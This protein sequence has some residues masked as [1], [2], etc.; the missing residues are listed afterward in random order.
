MRSRVALFSAL[1]LAV[2]LAVFVW[3]LAGSEPS[4][5]RRVDSP[6]LGRQAPSLGDDVALGEGRWTVVNFFATWCPPCIEEHPDLVRF[7]ERHASRGDAEVVSVVF[8]DEA[9]AVE[10][11]FADNGG[12]WPVV[13]D[14]DGRIA[15]DFG[16]TNVPES[17]LV[18]PDGVIAA[19]IVGGIDLESLE[20]LLAEARGA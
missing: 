20:A 12:D 1:G 8:G 6:L 2:V 15:V 5:A 9:R 10:A 7:A 18:S 4:T 3:V 17:Y 11:F 13:H 14:P 16:V 19:K